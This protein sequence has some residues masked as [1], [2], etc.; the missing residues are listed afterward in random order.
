MTT[1]KGHGQHTTFDSGIA[2]RLS[3][4][5]LLPYPGIFTEEAAL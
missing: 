1:H 3:I 2:N 4:F 5:F